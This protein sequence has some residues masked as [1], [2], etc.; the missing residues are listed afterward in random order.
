MP[1]EFDL[2]EAQASCRSDAR[3]RLMV[4]G[5]IEVAFVVQTRLAVW[6]LLRALASHPSVITR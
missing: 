4:K 2:Y 5:D 1:G 3:S 6:R